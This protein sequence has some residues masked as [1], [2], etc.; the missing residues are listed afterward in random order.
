VHVSASYRGLVRHHDLLVIGSGSGNSIVDHRFADLDVAMVEHGTF[1]GTCIN[2]GCVPTKMYVYPADIAQHIRHAGRLGLD[3]TLDKVRWRDIRDRIFG[4][5]DPIS[6]DGHAYRANR[7]PNFT[8][9]DGHARFTGPKQVSID[10]D[11]EIS[12]DRI[13][14]ATG[15]RPEVPDEVRDVP[16][17]TSDTVMRI[18]EVPEHLVIVGSG[19]IAAE[20]A[21]VFSAF[22]ARVSMIGRSSLLLR[23]QDE[24]VAEHFTRLACDRWDVHLGQPVATARGDWSEVALT[25][26]DGTVVRGDM[27]LVAAGRIP[28]GDLLD[29]EKAGIEADREGRVLVDDQQRT[30]VDGVFALGDASSP[31]QLKHVANHE[32]KVVQHNL[33]HPGSPRR[34]DH[35]FVPSAVFTDPQIASVGR[36]EAQ[37][38]AMGLDYVVKT[39]DY[40]DVAYGWAMVDKTGFCKLIA[41]RATGKLLGAHI[42]GP[43]AS[44][45]IQPVIQAMSFGLGAKEMASG[46]YWIHPGLPEVVENALLG[47][48]L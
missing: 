9:Y 43:Q 21:H 46:Q 13:V 25:L 20:F 11:V 32:A 7:S 26:L 48:D 42:M 29:L 18:E 12:A 3:A 16:H 24:T 10:G 33:L 8:L 27:L 34:T 45:L 23:N 22:G 1:G 44:T 40:A 31:F 19:Y 4:R 5:I 36:T 28:N 47:L 39:Q 35:R 30:S 38:R 14:I 6:V 15:G 37:C 17:H 2:V 41:D